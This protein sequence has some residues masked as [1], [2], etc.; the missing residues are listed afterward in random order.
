MEQA[1][2]STRKKE[3]GSVTIPLAM[4]MLLASLG[5]S[6]AN[7]ALPALVE[8][9][10][11]SFA[12]VQAVVVAYL[13]TLTV[14]VVIAGRIGDRYGLR[15]A[16]LA[17]L[18]LFA[19][20]SLTCTVASDLWWL[21]AARALQGLGAAFLMTLS[22]ALMRE[23]VDE[24]RMGR[25]M[26]LL[27]T[28]SALGTAM[29]PTLGGLLLVVTGWRGIFGVQFLLAAIVIMLV[30]IMLEDDVRK[31]ASSGKSL[32][33]VL[34]MA[35]VPNLLVNLLVAMVMM[36]TL[37][38]GPF[39]LAIALGLNEALTGFVMAVGPL[40]SILAG[41]PSGRLV[42]GWGSRRVLTIGLLLVG[43]GAILLAL[44]PG[45]LGV[46]GYVFSMAILTPGY[47]LF[48]AANNTAVM[49]DVSKDRRG[50]VSGLLALSRNAGL[51]LGASVMGTVFAFAVGTDSFVTAG[52]TEIGN[53][54][55]V[56][57]MVAGAMIVAAMFFLF[58]F[59]RDK[60][61]SPSAEGA[62]RK[63]RQP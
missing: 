51:V 46:G 4:A 23:R 49:A 58:V 3:K 18:C 12:E 22:M 38:V 39:Y 40:I 29:G 10:S 17:G 56:T 31:E 2:F 55:R 20:A 59:G 43:A 45:M 35:M 61:A 60:P 1:E 63:L 47:Q 36:T 13:A 42:D 52:A 9:F 14:T 21:I 5:T 25:A 11:S 8:V 41:A 48:Q 28:I 15:R 54:L 53:G 44:L 6:I 32:R 7:V 30:L 26:G 33:S 16:L 24:T 57:F 34:S 37:V 62:P 50:T 27:G 19:F